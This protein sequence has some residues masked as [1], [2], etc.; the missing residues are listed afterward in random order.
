ME[1]NRLIVIAGVSG[2]GKSYLIDKLKAG[3]FS[4]LVEKFKMGDPKVWNYVLAK[5]F[6]RLRHWM[7]GRWIKAFWVKFGH[8]P[9]VLKARSIFSRNPE[10]SKNFLFFILGKVIYL[11]TSPLTSSL[12]TEVI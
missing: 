7:R 6:K 9:L 1:V 4:E 2:V 12:F 3:Y 8:N 10:L 11:I 5:H